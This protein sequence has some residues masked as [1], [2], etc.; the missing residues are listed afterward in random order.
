MTVLGAI[1]AA[2]ARVIDRAPDTAVWLGDRLFRVA[3]VIA[4]L[5]LAPDIDR[6]ALIG[7]GEAATR[8]RPRRHADTI[9]VRAG[10][11]RST[12]VATC[13]ARPRTRRTRRRCR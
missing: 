10:T 5:P 2:A 13:S 11:E 6:S 12:A 8:L 3:G 9:Y 4:P 1:A 7:Y